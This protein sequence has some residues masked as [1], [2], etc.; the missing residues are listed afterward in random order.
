M[1]EVGQGCD[2]IYIISDRKPDVS[3]ER[4]ID[5]VQQ[6]YDDMGSG[7]QVFPIA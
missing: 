6:L 4:M 1:G 2:K 5:E 7:W 3:V